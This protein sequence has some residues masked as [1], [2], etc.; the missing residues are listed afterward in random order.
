MTIVAAAMLVSVGVSWVLVEILARLGTVAHPF[1]GQARV[2][3]LA[4][5][6]GIGFVVVAAIVRRVLLAG[7]P[8][9]PSRR[10]PMASVVTFALAEVPATCGLMVFMLT[11]MREAAYPLFVVSFA[12]LLLYFPRWGQWEEWA[13]AR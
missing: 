4:L 8:D 3:Y 6:L 9:D 5:A 11:G 13:K 2:G 10:I 7:A 1:A 12:G